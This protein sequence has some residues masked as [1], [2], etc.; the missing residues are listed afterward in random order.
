VLRNTDDEKA[1]RTDVYLKAK[2]VPAV[3]PDIKGVF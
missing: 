1:Q 2:R 3:D